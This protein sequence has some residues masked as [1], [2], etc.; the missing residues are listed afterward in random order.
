[1]DLGLCTTRHLLSEADKARPV[2]D[3]R[4]VQ[5]RTEAESLPR[6]K[7]PLRVWRAQCLRPLAGAVEGPAQGQV[8]VDPMPAWAYSRANA[9]DGQVAMVRNG[10]RLVVALLALTGIHSLIACNYTDGPCYRRE[11]VEGGGANGAGG[12]PIVPGTG[13][14]E[15]TPPPRPQSTT[16]P[17]PVACEETEQPD[18]QAD[19]QRRC[20]V[21]ASDACVEQCA[22]IGAYCVHRAVHP[23]KS[24][25]GI[26]D[27]Y[28][29][30]GG[31]PTYT[32]SYKY[33]NGDNCTIIYP[34]AW[35]LCLYQGGK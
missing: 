18:P 29:C 34:G 19:P 7:R 25:G 4:Q 8:S 21:P 6:S 14:F 32:C 22:D 16:D 9:R 24:D 2:T 12:G 23:K 1:M 11:D 30:K 35:S 13:G 20:A 28:W 5:E 33:S 31:W 15:D 3:P 17:R 10:D 26:G 27:L